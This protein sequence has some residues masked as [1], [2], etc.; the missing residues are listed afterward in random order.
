MREIGVHHRRY[1]AAMRVRQ[2]GDGQLKMGDIQRAIGKRDHG[3]A[4]GRRA[5]PQRVHGSKL[6]GESGPASAHGKG[7]AAGRGGNSE[8]ALLR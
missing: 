4:G 3:H 8:D 6:A 1:A 5:Q 7:D 2:I